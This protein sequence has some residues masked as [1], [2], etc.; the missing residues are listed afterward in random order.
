MRIRRFHAASS[1]LVH[2]ISSLQHAICATVL[3]LLLIYHTKL[4]SILQ[5]LKRFRL[6]N[7]PVEDVDFG[8]LASYLCTNIY[9]DLIITLRTY[10][11][12]ASNP[13]AIQ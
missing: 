8:S 1:T 12:P 10:K 3:L 4:T 5:K 2:P 11:F 7:E 13:A 6:Y 9:V